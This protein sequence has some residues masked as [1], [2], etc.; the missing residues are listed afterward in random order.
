MAD[1]AID[2]RLP[3]RVAAAR[4]LF[5][6]VLQMS[7]DLFA[8]RQE[9]QS[10]HGVPWLAFCGPARA[11]KDTAAQW[12]CQRLGWRYGEGGTSRILLPLIAWTLGL[13]TEQAWQE[14]TQ[15]RPFWR[16][17][18]DE[19]R[20]HDPSVIARLV[21]AQADVVTGIRARD[22]L[23][24]CVREG[25]VTATLWVQNSRVGADPTLEY[26]RYVCDLVLENEGGLPE[27]WGRLERLAKTFCLLRTCTA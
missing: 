18:M 13:S 22:E 20:R 10:A 14:R 17:F 2:E 11:G 4:G 27:L 6:P 15:Q 5:A 1:Y 21:L 8:W 25:V 24:A 23:D 26:D 9:R 19:F 3:Q 7:L 16:A 12:L